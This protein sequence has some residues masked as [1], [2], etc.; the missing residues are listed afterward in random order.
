[1]KRLFNKQTSKRMKSFKRMKTIFLLFSIGLLF[2]NNVKAKDVSKIVGTYDVQVVSIGWFYETRDTFICEIEIVPSTIDSFDIQYYL[3]FTYSDTVRAVLINDSTFHF[4]RQWVLYGPD[5][6]KFP[7]T[8]GSSEF[9]EYDFL[10][11]GEGYVKGDS[12]EITYQTHFLNPYINYLTGV[13]KHASGMY[14]KP[15]ISKVL[16]YPSPANDIINV[17]LPFS[18]FPCNNRSVKVYSIVGE[19]VMQ[20]EAESFNNYSFNI[21]GLKAGLYFVEIKEDGKTGYVGKFLKK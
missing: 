1:M 7:N 13:K 5:G 2:I 3:H 10:Y 11:E 8:I 6:S 16:L 14:D 17:Y 20:E 12:I 15:Q 9:D 19:C 21:S 18:D 4:D